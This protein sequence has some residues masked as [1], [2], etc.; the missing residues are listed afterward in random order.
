M[1]AGLPAVVTRNGGPRES[2][3]GQDEAYGILVDPEDPQS[4]ARGLLELAGNE[5]R[6]QEMQRQGRRRVLER[7]TWERTA[8]GY[9]GEFHRIGEGADAGR[10]GF[11][12][13]AEA[14]KTWLRGLYYGAE[15]S[16]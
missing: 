7:Y 12:E 10:R 8:E 3:T 2:L 5:S 11:E 6:R 9:L 16:T 15:E 1:A 13:P 14:G 4:I